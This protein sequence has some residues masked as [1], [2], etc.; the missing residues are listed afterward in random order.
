V[1][2]TFPL[3]AVSGGEDSRASI[4]FE[5][6]PRGF[7][8][9]LVT[10]EGAMNLDLNVLPCRETVP[11]SHCTAAGAKSDTGS[12]K[13]KQLDSGEWGSARVIAPLSGPGCFLVSASVDVPASGARPAAH[14]GSDSGRIRANGL[15][16][17]MACA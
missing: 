6:G 14:L 9:Q 11:G 10:P 1:S 13:A 8:F 3:F 5:N 12:S 7:C 17:A 2:G 16:E 4:A 15:A